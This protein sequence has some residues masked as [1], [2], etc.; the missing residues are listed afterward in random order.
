MFVLFNNDIFFKVNNLIP[1]QVEK[2]SICVMK[3]LRLKLN[4]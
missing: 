1:I 3:K 4:L 2:K